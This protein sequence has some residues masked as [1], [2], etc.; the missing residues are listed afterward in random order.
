[1][2]RIY[3]LFYLIFLISTGISLDT[4]NVNNLVKHGGKYLKENDYIPYDGIVFDISKETGNKIL[5]FRM[6]SGLKSG[7]YEEWYLNGKFKTKGEN[8]EFVLEPIYSNSSFGLSID[9]NFDNGINNF[10]DTST[11]DLSAIELATKSV[12]P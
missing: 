7:S 3:P 2:K 6:I 10:F 12:I 5:K 9:Y 1:M 4:V 8:S 11:I